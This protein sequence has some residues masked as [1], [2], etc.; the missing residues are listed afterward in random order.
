MHA[1]LTPG[2]GTLAFGQNSSLP[3]YVSQLSQDYLVSVYEAVQGIRNVCIVAKLLDELL[4]TSQVMAWYP[5]EEV[6]NRLEL[7]TS[8]E[9]VEP[10]R[11]VD[12][13]GRSQH[14]LGK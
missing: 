1:K 3:S 2:N 6:V 5:W 9:E 14:L 11:T 12:I 7:E 13:H 8:V 10:L 4:R